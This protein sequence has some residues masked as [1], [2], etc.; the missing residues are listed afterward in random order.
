MKNSFTFTD[1][2]IEKL[3]NDWPLYSQQ[4]DEWIDLVIERTKKINKANDEG[5]PLKNI[6]DA[7]ISAGFFTEAKKALRLYSHRFRDTIKMKMEDKHF[8]PM[9]EEHFEKMKQINVLAQKLYKQ[10]C[11]VHN[12]Y[13]NAEQLYTISFLSTY[14][15]TDFMDI[16]KGLS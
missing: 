16:V 8:S 3:I 10:F 6:N 1:E 2:T 4:Y 14:Q 9:S 7:F 12:S 11:D 5:V 15:K 13:K